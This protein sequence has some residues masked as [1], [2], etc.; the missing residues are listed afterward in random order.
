MGR[1]KLQSEIWSGTSDIA[2]V[3]VRL[4]ESTIKDTWPT[5]STEID[6]I[7]LLK[8]SHSIWRHVPSPLL[9]RFTTPIKVGIIEFEGSID[10]S[11]FIQDLDGG[12]CD[13]RAYAIARDGSDL[14]GLHT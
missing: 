14:E 12:C 4:V 11:Q 7:M 9:V 5:D 1:I 13:F 8:L 6:G 2:S 3:T 10:F